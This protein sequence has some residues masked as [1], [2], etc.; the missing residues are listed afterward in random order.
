MKHIF[1]FL[2]IL[3]ICLVPTFFLVSCGKE[4]SILTLA[5]IGKPAPDFALTDT[6][7]KTWTL[8]ELNGQAIFINFW[9]TWCP[10]CREE[11]PSMQNLYREL[12]SKGFQMLTILMNDD[13]NRAVIMAKGANLTFPI[14]V[15]HNGAASA[16]YGI[17]GVPETYIVDATGILREKIIGPRQWD[18][19]ESKEMIRKYIP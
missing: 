17:T 18:S 15:D 13:P 9:A 12:D 11:L 4:K 5:E 10:P 1:H 14:L 19:A 6:T 2:I 8:S 7:G 16:A 3:S